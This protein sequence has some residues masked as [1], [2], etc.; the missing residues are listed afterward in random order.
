M[1]MGQSASYTIAYEAA[2]GAK[3]DLC[4][5]IFGGDGSYYPGSSMKRRDVSVCHRLTGA[6]GGVGGRGWLRPVAAG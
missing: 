1:A 5:I 4:R 2:D 6:G 3:V